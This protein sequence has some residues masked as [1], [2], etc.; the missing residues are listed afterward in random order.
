MS[1]DLE[2][3]DDLQLFYNALLETTKIC[4][5]YDKKDGN[6][7]VKK[8]YAYVKKA[9]VYGLA[10]TVADFQPILQTTWSQHK[11]D[12]LEGFDDWIFK[13][14]PLILKVNTK[15]YLPIG[16]I[17]S[18]ITDSQQGELYSALMKAMLLF[19]TEPADKAKITALI[20]EKE[21]ANG[22]MGDIGGLLSGLLGG[23]NGAGMGAMMKDI[24]GKLSNIQ[25]NPDDPSTIDASKI[26]DIVKEML[27]DPSKTKMFDNMKLDPATGKLAEQV[28]RLSGK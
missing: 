7:H 24:M 17:Y 12:I 27:T 6:N 11:D 1:D 3:D 5:Q 23:E 21:Q 14:E 2:Q 9:P 13:P 8:F 19:A 20:G 10:K 15:V 28:K 26:G 25:A 4:F 22:G 18:R 16:N